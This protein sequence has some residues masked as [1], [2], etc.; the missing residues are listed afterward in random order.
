MNIEVK[1]HLNPEFPNG[2]EKTVKTWKLFGVTIIKKIYNYPKAK[3]Y[4]VITGQ[5]LKS[6]DRI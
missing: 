2:I 4:D 6:L 1:H 3:H 5:L